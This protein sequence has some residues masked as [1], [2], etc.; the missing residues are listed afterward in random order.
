MSGLGCT[1]TY[2]MGQV[3]ASIDNIDQ[4]IGS[5]VCVIGISVKCL[6]ISTVGLCDEFQFCKRLFCFLGIDCCLSPRPGICKLRGI[7]W[8][9]SI[10]PAR[11]IDSGYLE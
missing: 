6:D 10:V 8:T 9:R 2:I 4:L 3:S 7:L 5:H 11:L 1:K